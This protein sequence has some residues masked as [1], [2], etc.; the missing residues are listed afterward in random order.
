[1]SSM[2]DNRNQFRLLRA[3]YDLSFRRWEDEVRGLELLTSQP[4]A[5]PK[6]VERAQRLA[7]E[8]Q[9][10]YRESRNS[11]AQFL[12]SALGISSDHASSEPASAVPSRNTVTP[13]V[14]RLKQRLEAAR[15]H[16]ALDE[17]CARVRQLVR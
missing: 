17:E 15:E 10:A 16:S 7:E 5:D 1:M 13:D 12:V 14:G 6:A 11:L 2:N 9:N 3:E 8:A 4:N